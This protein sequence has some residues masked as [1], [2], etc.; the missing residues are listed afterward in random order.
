MKRESKVRCEAE[1]LVGDRHIP[2]QRARFSIVKTSVRAVVYR[3][4]PA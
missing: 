1:T 2:G 3:W 4:V